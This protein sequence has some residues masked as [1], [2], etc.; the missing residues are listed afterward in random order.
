[1]FLLPR[2]RTTQ[3]GLFPPSSLI[4][5]DRKNCAH[6]LTDAARNLQAYHN[7]APTDTV[8]VVKPA[9]GSANELVST[10]QKRPK[11]AR[12]TDRLIA[13]GGISEEIHATAKHQNSDSAPHHRPA[14]GGR[15]RIRT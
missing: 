13:E 7:I 14:A 8:N 4:H 1:M 6:D 10:P 12:N 11:K 2:N 9:A 5:V 3:S 15:H